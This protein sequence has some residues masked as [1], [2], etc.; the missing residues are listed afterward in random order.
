MYL[1]IIPARGGSKGL[2]RKNLVKVGGMSLIYWTINA[3]KNSTLLNEFI[4]ST[5]DTEIANLSKALDVKVPFIRPEELSGD[6]TPI[7]DVLNHALDFYE[8]HEIY[9][10]AIVLLQPT[11][12]LR[13][14]ED[15]DESLN[16]FEKEN[17]DTVVSVCEVPHQYTE[18]SIMKLE[19]DGTIVQNSTESLFRRQ[20]KPIYYARNGPA[21]IVIKESVIRSGILYGEK[22]YPYI[23]SKGNS[24]DID[25]YED[26]MFADYLLR[27]S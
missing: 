16:I 27:K 3:A 24:I 25:D 22:T 8:K 18:T 1:G 4:V 12:P 19:N 5:D 11:S 17:A 6:K 2:K 15:I 26:L 21:V 7:I 20:D 13:T 14:F 10:N 9:I 23:M